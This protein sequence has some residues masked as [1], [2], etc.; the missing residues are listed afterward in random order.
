MGL[1]RSENLSSVTDL[2]KNKGAGRRRGREGER[3]VSRSQM[4]KEDRVE[5]ES[6]KDR[7]RGD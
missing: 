5:R 6:R 3:R 1:M 4:E 2:N 7:A